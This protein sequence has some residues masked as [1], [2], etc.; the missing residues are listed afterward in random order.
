LPEARRGGACRGTLAARAEELN[1]HCQLHGVFESG[2]SASSVLRH[3]VDQRRLA[4][5]D[6][7]DR[8][9]KRRLEIVGV[10]DRTFGPPAL[11]REL[12]AGSRSMAASA[13]SGGLE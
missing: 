3:R 7:R 13:G 11:G 12:K 8:P 1:R 6:L 2:I 4:I 5:L 10:L 9:L